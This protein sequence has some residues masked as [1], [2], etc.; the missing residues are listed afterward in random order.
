[1]PVADRVYRGGT[2]HTMDSTTPTTTAVAVHDGTIIALGDADCSAVTD[3]TTEVVDLNGRTLVPGFHDAHA[4]PVLG[5]IG[6]RQCNLDD[7]HGYQAYLDR[8]KSYAENNPDK[9]WIFGSGWYGDVFEGGFPHRRDLDA[10]VSDRPAAFTSHDAHGTWVNTRALEAAGINRDTPDPDGGRIVKDDAGEPTGLLFEGAIALVADLFPKSTSHDVEEALLSSQTYFQSLGIVGW[11]DAGI[12]VLTGSPHDTYPPYLNLVKAQKFSNKVTGALW[13]DRA[14]PYAEQITTIIARRDEINAAAGE[15]ERGTLQATTVK[16]MLDGVCENLTG[17]LKRSY[18][19]HD[20]EHG[21]LMFDAEE[22]KEIVGGLE[23]HEFNIHIHAVGDEALKQA[24]D[25]LTQ[26]GGPSPQRRHQVA[27]LDIADP[28]ELARMAE[29]GIIANVQ[30][31]WARRDS[32]LVDTKLPLLN[33]DQQSNHFIFASMRDAGVRLSFG[34]DWPVSS[35]DPIWGM[36]VAVNRTAP[37][38]DPHGQDHVAQNEPLLADEKITVEQALRAYTLDA[39][40][41]NGYA[42]V[43]GSITVGKS[44]DFALLDRDPFT[45]ESEDL[46]D[47]LVEA[48]VS[49]G[50][51]VYQRDTVV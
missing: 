50:E 46:G 11:Q 29:A 39:A 15:R 25:A 36:H 17:A 40:Y 10:V 26:N 14:V 30:P 44:A 18:R 22:L 12:G 51:E 31:L 8:I 19:G 23:D 38:N 24:V 47:I 4:H 7:I 49:A 34:S 16:I 37:H 2:I 21:I 32:V 1:M 45:V 27:H 13:W 42:D 5:G 3:T 41:A 48:T 9:E 28:A 43:S 33:E 35:P 6:L 20:H